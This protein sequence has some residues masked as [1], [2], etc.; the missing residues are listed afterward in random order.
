MG[1]ELCAPMAN[2]L[3]GQRVMLIPA[4]CLVSIVTPPP[5]RQL[6]P[7]RMPFT[8]NSRLRE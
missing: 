5:V 6:T 7:T 2:M 3:L 4:W 1:Q 8:T